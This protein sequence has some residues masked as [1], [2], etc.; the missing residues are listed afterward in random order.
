MS[1]PEGKVKISDLKTLGKVQNLPRLESRIRT[2][3][4]SVK[5]N[6]LSDAKWQARYLCEIIG[7]KG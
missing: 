5:H 7:E 6:A 3:G 4:E 1:T 2:S